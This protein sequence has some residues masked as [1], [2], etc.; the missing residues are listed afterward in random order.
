MNIYNITEKRFSRAHGLR[1]EQFM[2]SW[3]QA[4]KIMMEECRS[5]AASFTVS[6]KQSREQVPEKEE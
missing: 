6:R 1:G 2:F 4:R 3:L 5:R